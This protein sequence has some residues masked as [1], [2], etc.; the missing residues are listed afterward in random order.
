ME[1]ILEEGGTSCHGSHT[2]YTVLVA[3]GGNALWYCTRVDQR[4][5]LVL[6]PTVVRL[7]LNANGPPPNVL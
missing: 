7:I 4:A 6:F 5:N 1:C 2:R 3:G